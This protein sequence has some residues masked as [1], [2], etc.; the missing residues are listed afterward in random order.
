MPIDPG[1]RLA[2]LRRLLGLSQ[3]E[4]SAM[5]GISQSHLSLME[6]G[7]RSLTPEAVTRISNATQTPATFFAQDRA[8]ISAGLSFRKL[9]SATALHTVTARFEEIERIVLELDESVPFPKIALPEVEARP[10]DD[11]AIEFTAQAT[12]AAF[13]IP[14]AGPILN[15]TR[16][17]ERK[18]L[19]VVPIADRHE[20]LFNKHDGLSRPHTT[21]TRPLVAYV[22]GGMGD[23]ERFTKAHELAHLVLHASPPGLTDRAKENEAN[24]FA[25][26]LLLPEA[27]MRSEVTES[28]SLNG[29]LRM[30]AKWGV[31]AQAIMYRAKL[32]GIIS[33]SRHKSLM[34]QVSYKG[35]RKEEPVLVR[36]EIPILLRQ[37][38]C[39]KFGTNPYMKAA[40]ALGVS[41]D[42]LRKW[43]PPAAENKDDDI[44]TVPNNVVSLSERRR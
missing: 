6:R 22:R 13:G 37:M 43:A 28:V 25:G 31:S 10:L 15:L 3:G 20:E 9:A 18:G 42:F 23:R 36:E 24:R 27:D 1:E 39:K 26:A 7:Q 29:Y 5:T 34:V 11:R 16:A 12:R 17:L 35:W 14:L 40:H 2:R 30:K 19:I 4:L 38:L 33:E 44:V 41:P 32:L 21:G 8:P